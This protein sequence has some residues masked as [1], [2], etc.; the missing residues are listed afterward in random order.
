[1]KPIKVSLRGQISACFTA[2][3][4]G[5]QV[6]GLGHHLMMDLNNKEANILA[7]LGDQSLAVLVWFLWQ[8]DSLGD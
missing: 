5:V 6:L 1:M 2:I 8:C 7:V 3:T 4:S